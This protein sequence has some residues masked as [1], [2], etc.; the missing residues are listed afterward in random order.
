M[1]ESIICFMI[2]LCFSCILFLEGPLFVSDHLIPK[3]FIFGLLCSIMARKYCNSCN[4]AV[5]P[6]RPEFNG[7]LCCLLLFTA[8]GWLIYL[9]I[10]ILLPEDRCPF[11]NRQVVHINHREQQH[12]PPSPRASSQLQENRHKEPYI[13][14]DVAY[15]E[16]AP[17]NWEEKP[18][19]K[20]PTTVY[21][22]YCGT[23]ISAEAK[24]CTACG[25]PL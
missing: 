4:T 10:Y 18:S 20:K 9:V 1:N 7:C 17:P 8:F 12:K 21:C 11:C 14:T 16:N 6:V 15:S 13:R 3:D 24:H 5:K 19:E 2:K 22:P 23:S 25:A